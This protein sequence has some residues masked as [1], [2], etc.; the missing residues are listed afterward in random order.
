M[1]VAWLGIAYLGS[2][3]VLFLNAFWTGSVHSLVVREFTLDNFVELL[4]T[5]VYR[6]SRS[7]R[8]R[9]PPW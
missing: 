9:W 8:S 2:L 1:P 7:E 4:T 3:V 6:S 5:D